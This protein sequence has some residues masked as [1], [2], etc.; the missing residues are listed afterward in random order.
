MPEKKECSFL[1]KDTKADSLT[2]INFH[3]TCP[4]DTVKRSILEKI[5]P[6]DW[7][8]KPQRVKGDG[9]RRKENQ[10]GN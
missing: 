5:L 2:R 7:D 1:L 9:K 6:T 4:D 8:F 10:L 3:M